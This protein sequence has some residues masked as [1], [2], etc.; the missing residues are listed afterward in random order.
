MPPFVFGPDA[1]QPGFECAPGQA[2][3]RVHCICWDPEGNGNFVTASYAAPQGNG[4]VTT[5]SYAAPQGNGNVVTA[6][7]EAAF[8][9]VFA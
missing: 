8:N 7:A 9:P 6:S 1:P 4:N 2:Q 5:A 3:S